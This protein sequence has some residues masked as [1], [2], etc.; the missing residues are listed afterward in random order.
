[1]EKNDTPENLLHIREENTKTLI[2][3]DGQITSNG[4]CSKCGQVSFS[5]SGYCIQLIEHSV[6]EDQP[7]K[8]EP[9]RKLVLDELIEI[10][11]DHLSWMEPEHD[12]TKTLNWA[13]SKA[14]SLRKKE[15]ENI[16]QAWSQGWIDRWQDNGKTAKYKNEIDYL[17]QTYKP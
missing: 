14:Q 1:M 15:E 17:T 12:Q 8:P 11:R 6:K 9:T 3:C 4:Y 2:A 16:K 13:I 10:F 5:S 7:A